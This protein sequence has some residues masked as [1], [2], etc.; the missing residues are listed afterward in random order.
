[1]DKKIIKVAVANQEAELNMKVEDMK[2]WKP[3]KISYIGTSAYFKIEENDTFYS[4]D[5]DDF[6]ALFLTK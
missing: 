2:D 5:R 3:T 6:T 4:M 1:M